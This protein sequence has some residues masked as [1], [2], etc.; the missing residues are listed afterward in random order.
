[1]KIPIVIL[2]TVIASSICS[3]SWSDSKV[4]QLSVTIPP[5]AVLS[6]LPSTQNQISDQMSQTQQIQRKD[7]MV[8]VTSI[9]AP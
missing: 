4:F 9:V 5:H 1:M 8:L 7:R 2:V 3:I 6:S